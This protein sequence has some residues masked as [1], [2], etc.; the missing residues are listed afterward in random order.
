MSVYKRLVADHATDCFTLYIICFRAP[1]KKLLKFLSNLKE[2]ANTN[3]SLIKQPTIDT[4]TKPTAVAEENGSAGVNS[5][6][7]GNAIVMLFA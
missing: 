4:G 2:D 7:F 5:D 3:D 6:V 1:K